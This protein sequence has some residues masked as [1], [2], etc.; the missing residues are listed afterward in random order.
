MKSARHSGAKT[1]RFSVFEFCYK[2]GCRGMIG[3]IDSMK[4]MATYRNTYSPGR[5]HGTIQPHY[6]EP[7]YREPH[8]IETR[9]KKIPL[10]R[11]SVI[12]KELNFP[13]FP[14]LFSNIMTPLQRNSLKV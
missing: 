9:Y 8:Y 14:F 5:Q 6:Y 1:L 7:R 11:I 3:F 12:T 2:L 13:S 4:S 10:Q